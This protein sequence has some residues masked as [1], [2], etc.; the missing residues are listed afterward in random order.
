M[1]AVVALI[2]L[3]G[4]RII[5]S[6]TRNWLVKENPG[7]LPVSF[8]RFDGAAMVGS[9]AALAAWAAH[10]E[11][12]LTEWLLTLAAVS[13]LFRL[14][15]W[16]GDRTLREPLLAALHVSYLFVPVGLALLALAAFDADA[17]SPLAGVHALGVGAIGGMTLS[18]MARA[19]LGHTGRPL[20]AGPVFNAL[21]ACLVV[22]A[23]ARIL[24]ALEF[25]NTSF[26]LHL[27][28]LGWVVAFGGFAVRFAPLFF[29]PRPRP[30]RGT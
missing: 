5:L 13:Q 4:G 23:L 17:F 14:A 3:I 22:A 16:A 19:T 18:V 9:I 29:R 27:S 20:R 2:M 28:V 30:K 25:G 15:R 24:E 26:L 21:F 1:A 10:P 8:D 11:T 6:F 12:T 7:R